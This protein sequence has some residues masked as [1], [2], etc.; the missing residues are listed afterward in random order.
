MNNKG[1]SLA[2]Y[3]VPIITGLFLLT[4][5]YLAVAH[6]M[7]TVKVTVIAPLSCVING[8]KPI[9]VDFGNTIETGKVNGSNYIKEVDYEIDCKNNVTNALRM[10]ISGQTASFDSKSLKTDNSNLGVALYNGDTRLTVN[11]AFNF[12]WPNKPILKA[13]PVKNSAQTLKSGVF[14][15]AAI[16]TVD[17]Q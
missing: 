9:M 11:E 2:G 1:Q 15:G 5:S 8:N 14:T 16:M 13:V 6:I 7:V 10:K 4:I 12:T 17:Y 3:A